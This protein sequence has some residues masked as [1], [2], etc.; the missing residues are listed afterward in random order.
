MATIASGSVD[1]GRIIA[2]ASDKVG[3]TGSTVV[4][5]SQTLFDENDTAVSA[6][7]HPSFEWRVGVISGSTLCATP[8]RRG[9][10]SPLMTWTDPSRK[11]EEERISRSW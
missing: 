6:P 3:D 9:R 2:Q 5:E 11:G 7:R 1:M 10:M 4:E 8:N